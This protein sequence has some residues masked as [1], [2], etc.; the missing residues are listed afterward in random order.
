METLENL[1]SFIV[2][3][4]HHEPTWAVWQE[5]GSEKKAYCWYHLESD[6][7]TPGK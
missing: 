1:M 2:P 4:F 6:R 3:I 5:W 7:E